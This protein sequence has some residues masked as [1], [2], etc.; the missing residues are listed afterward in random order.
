M[1][2]AD[3]LDQTES[4]LNS[5]Q[6]RLLDLSVILAELEALVQQNSRDLA[7]ARNVTEEA[8]N[9]S[10][11]VDQVSRSLATVLSTLEL[12]QNNLDFTIIIIIIISVRCCQ[13]HVYR[14]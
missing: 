1:Q 11:A 6:E 8:E 9:A 4:S 5:T 7:T 13:V 3:S 10:A 2:T 12:N 14:V